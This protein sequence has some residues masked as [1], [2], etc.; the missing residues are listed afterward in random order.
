Y[1][2]TVTGLP[3]IVIRYDRDAMARYQLNIADVN[4]VIQTAFAGESAGMIYENERR[5]DLVVRL[6][7]S[8][9]TNVDDVQHLLI[10]TPAGIQI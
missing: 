7:Q 10:N 4:Q 6:K 2:E 8:Q 3:Q 1:I 5:F 9:R